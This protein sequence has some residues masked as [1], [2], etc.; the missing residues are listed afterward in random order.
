MLNK[1]C[2]IYQCIIIL[3]LA[4]CSP[5][6]AQTIE[7]QLDSAKTLVY[8]NPDKSIV[9]AQKIAENNDETAEN[10]IS[11]L[12]VLT[13]AYAVKYDYENA[14]KYAFAANDIAEKK[15]SPE[16]RIRTLGLI[17]NLYQMLHMNDKVRDYMNRA[18]KIALKGNIPDSLT[19]NINGNIFAVKGNSY[20]DDLDCSYAVQYY[21]LRKFLTRKASSRADDYCL[22]GQLVWILRKS[23]S[24]DR[25][26]CIFAPTNKGS[27]NKSR[28]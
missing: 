13:N 24:P 8:S 4:V 18:E 5:I 22:L 16:Y 15:G 9:L 26:I 2:F 14:L 27:S 12:I 3:M 1:D 17:G 19:H 28:H 7:K 20:K 10:K 21:N 23:T 6:Y 25:T 11:A